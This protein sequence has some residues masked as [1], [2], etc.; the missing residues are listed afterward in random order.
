MPSSGCCRAC[1]GA[2]RLSSRAQGISPSGGASLRAGKRGD[3]AMIAPWPLF[4]HGG[5][6]LAMSRRSLPRQHHRQSRGGRA[7]RGR[8][9][10]GRDC[11]RRLPEFSR[12]RRCCAGLLLTGPPRPARPRIRGSRLFSKLHPLRLAPVSFVTSAMI[13]PAARSISD[14]VRVFPRGCKVTEIAT[15]F[16][17]S[18]MPLPS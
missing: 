15:D 8:M 1:L 12:T 13:L 18:A 4:S 11:R 3:D 5:T 10:Q 16:L 2:M 17:P 9:R 14:S 7:R 6:K